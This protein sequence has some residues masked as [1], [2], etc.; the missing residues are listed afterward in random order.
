[1]TLA[2]ELADIILMFGAFRY[3]CITPPCAAA[4]E[5]IRTVSIDFLID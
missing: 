4:G 2:G 1:M 5:S 3:L